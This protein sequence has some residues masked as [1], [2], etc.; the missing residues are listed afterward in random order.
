[1]EQTDWDRRSVL[2]GLAAVAGAGL[3]GSSAVSA[4]A[5]QVKYSSGTEPPKLKVPA[6]ACDCHHHIYGSQYKVDPKSTLRPGDA[7]VED[8]RAFQKRIGTSRNV[9]VQPSTY[10][11]ENAPTLD[12]LVAFGPSARAVVVV[13]TNVPDAALERMHHQR[14]RG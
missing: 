4:M 9:I 10:G 11:T 1:M 14:A 5:Q 12:A 8:Y 6:N 3:L 2:W 13:D 7:T